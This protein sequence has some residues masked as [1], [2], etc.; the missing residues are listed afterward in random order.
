MAICCNYGKITVH[1][2]LS[3]ATPGRS[4]VQHILSFYRSWRKLIRGA[5]TGWSCT[6]APQRLLGQQRFNGSSWSWCKGIVSHWRQR[7]NQRWRSTIAEVRLHTCHFPSLGLWRFHF[8]VGSS[9][10]WIL[11]HVQTFDQLD[12][13]P[14]GLFEELESTVVP[15]FRALGFSVLPGFR[16]LKAGAYLVKISVFSL[17]NPLLSPLF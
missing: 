1:E 9:Y 12:L 7:F 6:G 14:S 4:L 16:A 17:G 8:L 2:K 13:K 11:G 5:S 15:G 3:R 10:G